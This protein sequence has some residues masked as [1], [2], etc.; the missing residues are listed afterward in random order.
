MDLGLFGPVK[1]VFR[2]LVWEWHGNQVLSRQGKKTIKTGFLRSG[3]FPWNPEAVRFSSLK[4]SSKFQIDEV[5]NRS[6][7]E[8][9]RGEASE[10]TTL[11]EIG[12]NESLHVEDDITTMGDASPGG[13]I[14][15][16]LKCIEIQFIYLL[17]NRIIMF[18]LRQF[19]RSRPGSV[20]I[21]FRCSL[22]EQLHNFLSSKEAE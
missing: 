1:N 11:N 13:E 12:A 5:G 8:M 19:F 3:L 16:A 22:C 9:M 2:R 18:K 20:S 10:E 15:I 7:A 14:D 21:S 6:S 17:F 4:P